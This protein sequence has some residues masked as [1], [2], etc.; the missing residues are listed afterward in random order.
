MFED[1]RL[2]AM[3]AGPS[4]RLYAVGSDGGDGSALVALHADPPELLWRTPLGDEVLGA[5]LAL[6]AGRLYLHGLDG[7]DAVPCFDI[8]DGAALPGVPAADVWALAPD[9]DGSLLVVRAPRWR[10]ARIT[11]SGAPLPLW[12]RSGLLGRVFGGRA[13]AIA[14]EPVARPGFL[15][16]PGSLGMGQDGDL[17]LSAGDAVGRLDRQGRLRWKAPLPDATVPLLPPGAG[18]DGTTW[19]TFVRDG[20]P[21]LYRVEPDGSA[22]MAVLVGTLL[23]VSVD[24]DGG[25][26]VLSPGLLRRL[27][28][29]GAVTWEA[30]G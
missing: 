23:D 29:S 28:P 25:C 4:G 24:P 18:P 17:R 10:L 6:A 26:W 20:Q 30:P 19:A 7:A 9:P 5:R 15:P 2:E 8:T 13:S 16:A 27:D 21:T 12:P 22:P 11:R 3:T 1:L 14:I